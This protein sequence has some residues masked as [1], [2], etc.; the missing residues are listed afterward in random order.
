MAREKRQLHPQKS[1]WPGLLAGVAVLVLLVV[2][3]GVGVIL[4]GGRKDG[5]TP[6][7][8]FAKK[9]DGNGEKGGVDIA[10]IP[11][12][13]PEAQETR[14]DKSNSTFLEFLGQSRVFLVSTTGGQ[15]EFR[16]NDARLKGSLLGE[17][18]KALK[19]H[20]QANFTKSE[21]PDPFEA[22]TWAKGPDPMKLKGDT[23][24]P[25]DSSGGT[26]AKPLQ[27]DLGPMTA[28]ASSL[29]P[30]S[31][32]AGI[33]FQFPG[34]KRQWIHIKGKGI[35]P[36]YLVPVER[37]RYPALITLKVA[38]GIEFDEGSMIAKVDPKIKRAIVKLLK[39]NNASQKIMLRAGAPLDKWGAAHGNT[40][41]TIDFK[42]AYLESKIVAANAK[43]TNLK[44][45]VQW[46]DNAL[47]D[48]FPAAQKVRDAR[49]A[50][51]G[52]KTGLQELVKLGQTYTVEEKKARALLS[53]LGI[54]TPQKY[55]YYFKGK[56]D[57]RLIDERRDL[58]ANKAHDQLFTDRSGKQN[59]S[60]KQKFQDDLRVYCRARANWENKNKDMVRRN[61]ELPRKQ[62]AL[63]KQETAFTR[64]SVLYLG[65]GSTV[66]GLDAY[67]ANLAKDAG[68]VLLGK[69]TLS[70]AKRK[71]EDSKKKMPEDSRAGVAKWND[72]M[73]QM[74]EWEKF[75]KHQV[76]YLTGNMGID[77]AAVMSLV[78]FN[79]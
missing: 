20:N 8:K 67:K 21:N 62:A 44:H 50:V 65:K 17:F 3:I 9:P 70:T 1:S 22:A 15:A 69:A 48:L 51:E 16:E 14:G 53:S 47:K 32:A 63:K 13:K 36:F 39:E 73:H 41:D 38:E 31:K 72:K 6:N 26:Q 58:S 49:A 37:G 2:G 34:D 35:E 78:Q 18:F 66:P 79:Q 68:Q 19:T 59:V 60:A 11:G 40:T 4:L 28:L 55:A 61:Q 42:K 12:E 64:I 76:F 74:N 71:W 57:L 46:T 45:F 54:N 10:S 23:Q 43:V 33:Y 27:Y 52:N 25:Y 5:P 30:A 77:G 56:K 29:N 75:K 7:G 24:I